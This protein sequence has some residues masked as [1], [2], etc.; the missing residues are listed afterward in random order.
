[1]KRSLTRWTGTLGPNEFCSSKNVNESAVVVSTKLI[2]SGH[3]RGDS[4]RVLLLPSVRFA[5]CTIL[6]SGDLAPGIPRHLSVELIQVNERETANVR[7][8]RRCRNEANFSPPV[9]ICSL[10]LFFF[11]PTSERWRSS[12][13]RR[14]TM[15][16]RRREVTPDGW[17]VGIIERGDGMERRKKAGRRWA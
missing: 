13:V 16:S 17:E 15:V 11:L 9:F 4:P 12:G 3:S 7:C 5:L 8:S 1:M 14:N 2:A 10:S 6:Y